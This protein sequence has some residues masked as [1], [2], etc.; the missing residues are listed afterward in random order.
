MLLLAMQPF[1]RRKPLFGCI[2]QA[3]CE[4]KRANSALCAGCVEQEEP[5]EVP[6]ADSCGEESA[7][8]GGGG[9][10][11]TVSDA[12]DGREDTD[13]V[14]LGSDSDDAISDWQ[15]SDGALLC[16]CS[17]HV[18]PISLLSG[19]VLVGSTRLTF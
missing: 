17:L 15:D 7:E 12:S 4:W 6:E 8:D 5:P 14:S 19:P 1:A 10:D 16:L 3:S 18:E 11:E 9:D 13:V 2:L